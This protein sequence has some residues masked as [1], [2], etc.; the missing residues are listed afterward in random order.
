MLTRNTLKDV[1]LSKRSCRGHYLP[2]HLLQCFAK[3]TG[4]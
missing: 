3:D 2:L 4:T 1:F